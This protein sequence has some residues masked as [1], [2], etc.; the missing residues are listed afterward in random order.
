MV[1]D[2]SDAFRRVM[3]YV[4]AGTRGGA[5]R[6]RIIALLKER[7]YNVNQLSSAMHMDY[8]T[9]QHHIKLLEENRLIYSSGEK[10]YGAVYFTTQ[11]LEQNAETF[12][13]IARKVNPEIQVSAQKKAEGGAE[14]KGAKQLKGKGGN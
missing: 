4:L 3:W 2:L 1:R 13:E 12:S 9:I 14:E 6:V 11:L 8:K 5:T 10:K 7:P